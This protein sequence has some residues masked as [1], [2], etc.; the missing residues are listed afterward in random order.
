MLDYTLTAIL[1]VD[2]AEPLLSKVQDVSRTSF[3]HVITFNGSS[4]RRT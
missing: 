4:A 2:D 3:A 1:D